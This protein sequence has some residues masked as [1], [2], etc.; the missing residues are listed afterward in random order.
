[1]NRIDY[2]QRRNDFLN[3]I[4][5]VIGPQGPHLTKIK[6]D[7]ER[8]SKPNEKLLLNYLI[9]EFSNYNLTKTE[10]ADIQ[11]VIEE[12]TTSLEQRLIPKP[13]NKTIEMLINGK[14]NDQDRE[15]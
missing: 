9:L 12:F 8:E 5:Q 1:M 6:D 11:D 7:L 14:K 3:Y 13:L 15:T 2:Q 10:D 4:H